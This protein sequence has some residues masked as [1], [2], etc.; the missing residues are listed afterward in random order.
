MGGIFDALAR[1]LSKNKC[2]KETRVGW[3]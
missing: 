1:L 3:W 2:K